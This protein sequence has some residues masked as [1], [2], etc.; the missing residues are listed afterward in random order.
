MKATPIRSSNNHFM[1]PAQQQSRELYVLPLLEMV[2]AS[3]NV[4]LYLVV[5]QV[6]PAS[7]L[8]HY[9]EVAVTGCQKRTSSA[10]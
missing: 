4:V 5:Q 2:F 1:Q 8:I 3:R 7:D 10:V 9:G 6:L